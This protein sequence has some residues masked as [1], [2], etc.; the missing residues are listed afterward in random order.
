MKALLIIGGMA[1]QPLKELGRKTPL[2]V[3]EKP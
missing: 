2:E 1:D 3:A